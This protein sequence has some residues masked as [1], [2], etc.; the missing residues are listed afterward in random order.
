MRLYHKV[1]LLIADDAGL[2]TV[3][4]AVL[5]S[6]LIIGLCVTWQSLGD[7]MVGIVEDTTKAID[8][9]GRA[10]LGCLSSNQ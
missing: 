5:L 7:A 9:P 3:E 2:T 10:A 8:P 1:Q 6:G 4:Y